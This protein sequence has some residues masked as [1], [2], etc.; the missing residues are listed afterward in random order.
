MAIENQGAPGFDYNTFRKRLEDES[1][2]GQQ[3]L[4]LK[5]RLDLLESFMDRPVKAGHTGKMPVFADDKSGKRAKKQWLELMDQNRK[6]ERASRDRAWSFE[7]GVLTVVDLS[8]PFVDD[9]AACALFNI[10]LELF[11]ESRG[12]VGRIVA[13]DEAHKVRLLHA[14]PSLIPC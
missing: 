6:A 5:L 9:N 3:H 4:P 2:T 7:P 11:L 1:F 10:C 14:G 12:N 13:L 8:C